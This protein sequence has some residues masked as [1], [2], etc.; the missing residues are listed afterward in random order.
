MKFVHFNWNGERHLGVLNAENKVICFKHLGIELND[1]NAFIIHYD[2][3]KNKLINLNAHPA[4]EVPKEKLLAPIT[5]P[6]QDII[7]LGI[8]FLDHAKESAKFK[9]EN[10]EERKYPVYFGKRV[11]FASA[12]YGKIPLHSEVTNQ[13]DYECELA[14]ILAK[15]AYKIK[16]DEAKNYIFGY[17]IINEISARDLQGKH[18]QFYRAKSLEGSTIMG[19][20]IVSID[21][22]S[23]PPKLQ[24][25][26]YVNGELRQDDNTKNFIFDIA[27]VLEELSAGM[28]L[29]AGS[30]ISMGTPSGVGMGLNPPQFLKDQDEV[31]CEIEKIGTLCNIIDKNL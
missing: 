26:S 10:F 5:E 13:L 21:E 4:I 24:L 2:E 30:I 22:L 15:D 11:N 7:C 6:L 25:K 31:R 8:N 18:K 20:C 14:F 1:M 16:A 9:G 12:P 17:T 23:Y 29:K 3:F 27:Y 28:R 19:P